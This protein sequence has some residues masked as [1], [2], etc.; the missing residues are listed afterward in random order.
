[1]MAEER[2]NAK[3]TEKKRWLLIEEKAVPEVYRKVLRVKLRLEE[4]SAISVNEACRE[5]KLSRSTFYK[6][7]ETVHPY[8]SEDQVTQV[9]YQL[10][11][12]QRG[13]IFPRLISILEK[14]KVSICQ[15]GQSL[16]EAGQVILHLSIKVASRKQALRILKDLRKLPGAKEVRIFPDWEQDM[17]L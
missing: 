2:Q 13:L 17:T 11:L 5:E 15:A 8:H 16:Y 10:L 9:I 12:E 14:E 7:R 3:K 4:E 6:Y 1:M